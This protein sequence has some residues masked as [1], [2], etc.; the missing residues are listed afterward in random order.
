MSIPRVV[1][2]VS[3]AMDVPYIFSTQSRP[4]PSCYHVPS[5]RD[6]V[7]YSGQPVC[8]I[9]QHSLHFRAATIGRQRI[10]RTTPFL[11]LTQGRLTWLRNWMVG[12]LSGYWSP[13]CIL[14]E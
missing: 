3:Y 8:G 13:Q 11:G 4:S 1:V 6:M 14:R 12:G 2:E 7:V 10:V 5:L 9:R